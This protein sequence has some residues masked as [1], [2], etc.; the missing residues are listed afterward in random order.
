MAK[1]KIS[2]FGIQECKSNFRAVGYITGVDKDSFYKE[3]VTKNGKNMRMVNV[4]LKIDNNKTIYL[5]L[6]GMERDY[7][8]FSGKKGDQMITE[9]VAWKDRESYNKPNM[10]P[11]GVRLG[12]TKGVNDK[13]EVRNINKTFADFDACAEMRNYLED[14]SAVFVLGTIEYS[15]YKDEHKIKFIPSQISL[16][17][18]SDLDFTDE[19]NQSVFQ[20][21]IV[22]MGVTKNED[23][24]FIVSAKIVGYNTIEDAEFYVENPSLAKK[25]KTLKPYTAINVHG[26]IKVEN[27]TEIIEEDDGWGDSNPFNKISA[28]T[29]KKLVITGAEGS[30]VDTEL[31]SEKV[32]EEAIAKM[33]SVKNADKDYGK[34]SD[35]EWGT[36]QSKT[37][38]DDDDE[39]D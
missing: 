21:E 26:T 20:Q 9:K 15:V 37:P 10:Q 35:D 5:N 38:F 22:Y 11:I 32:I 19:K 36:P 18:N 31:Y 39:W 17:S 12:L 28:P 7:V 23:D 1:A 24:E 27:S 33:N 34:K 8:Y 14:D 16:L 13:G 2:S 30:S 29:V 6:N 3:L 4:G 25:F